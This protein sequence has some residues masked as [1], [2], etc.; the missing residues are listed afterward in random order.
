[1]FL[2]VLFAY[3]SSTA[4]RHARDRIRPATTNERLTEPSLRRRSSRFP[5]VNR[6]PLSAIARARM[7]EELE[8]SAA[9]LRTSEYVALRIVTALTI[10][11]G[12]AL[13]VLAIS[14]G[15]VAALVALGLVVVGWQIP[16]WYV[17]HLA[18]RRLRTIEEQIPGALTAIAKSLRAG[19]GLMQS[20]SFAA[21]EIPAPLGEELGRALRELRL[22][23]DPDGVFSTLSARVGS[24]DLD[25]AVTAILIQRSVGGNLAEILTNVTDTV[26]ERAQLHREVD[27]LTTRQRVTGNLMALM[28]VLVAGAFIGLN[29]DTGRLLIDTFAGRVSLG[30]GFFFEVL[31]L[32]LIRKFGAIEV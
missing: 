23:A 10:A 25:I 7:E 32:L 2:V 15:A 27:V 8:R 24:A 18:R 1:V 21:E 29:P 14:S 3:Q 11:V 31:G 12:G 22:G 5:L 20:L 17:S 30:I 26:R 9:P 28:P 19:S 13:A 6:L 4:A 16:Q